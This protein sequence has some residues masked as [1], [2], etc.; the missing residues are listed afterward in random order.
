METFFVTII[1]E[2]RWSEP[3]TQK[4]ETNL[5]KHKLTAYFSPSFFSLA[6]LHI[7]SHSIPCTR[8]VTDQHY[9]KVTVWSWFLCSVW[10]LQQCSFILYFLAELRSP[11]ITVTKCLNCRGLVAENLFSVLLDL[12]MFPVVFG[13]QFMISIILHWN[14]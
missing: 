8:D 14:A 6:S 5:P 13:F 10:M 7:G 11:A 2:M 12:E 4:A 3:V 9:V 1:L